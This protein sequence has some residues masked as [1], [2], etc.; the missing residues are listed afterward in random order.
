MD[1][2]QSKLEYLRELRLIIESDTFTAVGKAEWAERM[3]RVCDSIEK[4]LGI[5]KLKKLETE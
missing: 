4:D 3:D 2:N 5:V 1:P